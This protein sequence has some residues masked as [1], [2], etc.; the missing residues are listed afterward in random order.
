MVMTTASL[1]GVSIQNN[2][3]SFQIGMRTQKVAAEQHGYQN[4]FQD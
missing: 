1:S 2:K 3:L 4:A